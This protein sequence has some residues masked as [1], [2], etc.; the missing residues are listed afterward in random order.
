VGGE[1]TICG[2]T[3]GGAAMRELLLPSFFF[4]APS[5]LELWLPSFFVGVVRCLFAA[6]VVFAVVGAGA[7]HCRRGAAGEAQQRLL[8][9]ILASLCVCLCVYVCLRACASYEATRLVG[10]LLRTAQPQLFFFFCVALLQL[11]NP[12][13][14]TTTLWRRKKEKKQ[15]QRYHLVGHV[16]FFFILSFFLMICFWLAALHDWDNF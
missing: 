10:L 8:S 11:S 7:G 15:R 1:A 14:K 13:L 6:A 12:T 5:L 16:F 4:P 9:L 2:T 3:A